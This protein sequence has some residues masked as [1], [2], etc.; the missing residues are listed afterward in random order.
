MKRKIAVL[1]ISAVLTFA[2]SQVMA[3]CPA[4][5]DITVKDGYFT[6][7]VNKQEW[8]SAFKTDVTSVNPKQIYLWRVLFHHVKNGRS[9]D[10]ACTYHIVDK[11]LDFELQPV[12]QNVTYAPESSKN[13]QTS[14]EGKIKVCFAKAD[15]SFVPADCPFKVKNPWWKFW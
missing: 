10:V 6:A 13:W 11:K 8:K 9:S 15:Q 14:G 3:N 1:L 5:K 2:F 12:K 4:F 7:M